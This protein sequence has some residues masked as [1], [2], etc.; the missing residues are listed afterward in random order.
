MGEVSNDCTVLCEQMPV[1]VVCGQRKTPRGRA[2]PLA[3]YYC[4][5]DCAGY[6]QEPRSGHL[7]PGE[8]AQERGGQDGD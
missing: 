8:V 7:W 4:D 5:S 3:T 1:C 2:Q 6:D